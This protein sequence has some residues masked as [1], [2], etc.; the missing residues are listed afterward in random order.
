MFYL[1]NI[2]QSDNDARL[3]NEYQSVITILMCRG[4]MNLFDYAALIFP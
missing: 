2:A 3:L 1:L 4:A